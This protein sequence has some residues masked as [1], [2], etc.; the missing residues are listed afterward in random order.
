MPA[1]LAR[2]GRRCPTLLTTH[3]T[4][5][6]LRQCPSTLSL[7]G[8]LTISGV[9]RGSSDARE[10]LPKTARVESLWHAGRALMTSQGARK[11]N[12]PTDHLHGRQA[13]LRPTT[14]ESGGMI[15][16]PEGKTVKL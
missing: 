4:A 16:S 9:L 11:A 13:R 12:A 2:R 8:G 10:D 7:C 5:A 14:P 3:L 6:E 1:F 15:P